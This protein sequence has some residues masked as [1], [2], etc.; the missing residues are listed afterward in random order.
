MSLTLLIGAARSGKSDL[1]LQMAHA[2]SGEVRFIATAEAR[3]EEMT[4]R[5]ER[6]RTQRP[7]GWRTVEEPIF[8][9]N[10]IVAASAESFVIVDC[11]TLW[12]SNLLENGLDPPRIEEAAREVSKV[13]AAH[14][15]PVVVV[16]NEVGAGIVPIDAAVRAYRDLLGGVNQIFADQA[17][18]VL[19]MAAGRAI[20]LGRPEE[21][22]PH[23]LGR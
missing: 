20:A 8:I 7:P 4:A 21:V 18:D 22:V 10:E 19:L 11:L 16:S 15:S 1:A 12:V 3:D 6:H 13:A 2:W 9:G 5:I 17:D 14:T 23:L